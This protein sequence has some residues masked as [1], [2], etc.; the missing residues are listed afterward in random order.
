[1]CFFKHCA[2]VCVFPLRRERIRLIASVE[3]ALGIMNIKE[4]VTADPRLDAL[5]VSLS[6]RDIRKG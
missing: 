4:I 5:I 2:C 1:M 3:S 6:E